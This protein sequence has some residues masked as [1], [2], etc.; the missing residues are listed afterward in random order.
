LIKSSIII[1]IARIDRQ[2]GMRELGPEMIKG[3]N[4][5]YFYGMKSE[6]L[7]VQNNYNFI[8]KIIR[9]FIAPNIIV[10]F[11]TNPHVSKPLLATYRYFSIKTLFNP[12]SYPHAPKLNDTL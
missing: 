2:I 10:K 3:P 12:E 9:W 11:V 1:S 5:F 4:F 8:E 7:L 6:R